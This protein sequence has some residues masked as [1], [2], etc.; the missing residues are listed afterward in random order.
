MKANI[1]EIFSSLQG[2]GPYQGAAQVFIRFQGCNL[3]CRYCDTATFP[4][5][6]YTAEEL[7]R[8]LPE[9]AVHSISITGGEPLC[10]SNFLKTFLPLLKK[11]GYIIYLETN[12]TLP[13][14]L[15]EVV[16]F[17]DVIAM[18]I[19]LPSSTGGRSYWPEHKEFL[20]TAGRK[21]TFV[22]VVVTAETTEADLLK[23]VDIISQTAPQ[24]LLVLQPA[25]P[26]GLVCAP[27]EQKISTFERLAAL[28]IQN[29]R[30]LPQ[31]HPMLGIK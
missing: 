14:A 7:L 25:T 8:A 26:V 22:K 19:K 24:T 5:Y 31:L 16:D 10:Q 21:E 3:K 29:V 1:H 28:N 2:E 6:Q 30:V 13:R 23:A 11:K 18:D 20:Q 9:E 17:V 12:G 4:R 15:G 27:P